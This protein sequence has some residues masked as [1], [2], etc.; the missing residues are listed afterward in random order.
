MFPNKMTLAS[1]TRIADLD[2]QPFDVEAVDRSMWATGDYAVGEVTETSRSTPVEL[3]TGR[4]TEVAVGDWIVGALG[5]RAAT[6]EA[7]GSWLDVG[8]DLRLNAMNAAGM[9][10]RVTSRSTF[11]NKPID[12]AYRGHVLRS[13]RKVRMQD[14]VQPASEAAIEFPVLMLIGTSMSSGKTTSAKVI[15]RRLKQMGLRVVGAKLTGAGRYRDIL[16]M[17]DAGADAIFDF[18]DAGLPSTVC[19]E[20]VYLASLENLLSRIAE[21]K[22]DVLVAEA[23]A[24]PLEPYN[25]DAAVSR[26]RDHVRCTVLC[27]SD[28]YAVVGVMKGFGFDPDLVS[29]VATSTSAGVDVIR[30]LAGTPALNLLDVSSHRELDQILKDRLGF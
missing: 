9:L 25:G 28:P 2:R 20:S 10:G 13:G 12:L 27:A 30:K 16:A 19:E 1:L 14:F 17:S 7:V 3:T 23:G 8:D 5:V 22:P 29:G 18:V 15:I 21:A 24:S 6:L 11:I 26:L 4:L